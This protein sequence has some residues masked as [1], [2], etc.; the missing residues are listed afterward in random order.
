[1]ASNTLQKKANQNMQRG[2]AARQAV[3]QTSGLSKLAAK[4]TKPKVGKAALSNVDQVGIKKAQ[5]AYKAA[6]ASGDK[7][8]MAAA[9]A[10]AEGIRAKRGFSGGKTGAGETMLPKKNRNGGNTRGR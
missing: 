2:I 6:V 7:K 8:A 4:V 5:A 3:S 1:M 9:H 10:Q